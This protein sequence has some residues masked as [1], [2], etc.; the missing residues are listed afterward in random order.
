MIGKIIGYK[1]V[2]NVGEEIIETIAGQT[3]LE[4][5]QQTQQER[6]AQPEDHNRRGEDRGH[7]QGQ[8]SEKPMPFQGA[9]RTQKHRRIQTHPDHAVNR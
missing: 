7:S 1:D 3:P 8:E 6:A 2:W 5:S 9:P 4:Q